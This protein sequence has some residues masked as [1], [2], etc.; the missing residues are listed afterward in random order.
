MLAALLAI[1][2][3]YSLA[4]L[5]VPRQGLA[6][7]LTVIPD[8]YQTPVKTFS[9]PK[10]PYR[11]G[12]LL[13]HGYGSS[14]E[15]MQ[16]LA[17]ELAHDGFYTFC[18]D[19]PGCGDSRQSF[20]RDKNLPAL[21]SAYVDLLG[22]G[23]L[24]PDKVAI[25][26][27]SMGGA[28]ALQF[29]HDHQE[30][31]AAVAISATQSKVSPESPRNLLLLTAHND[32]PGR[33]MDASRMLQDAAPDHSTQMG[34]TAGD[35]ANG[36]ARRAAVIPNGNHLTILFSEAASKEIRD[37]LRSSFQ[38]DSPAA[39]V[40]PR[41][42]W[43]VLAHLLALLLF[44]PLAALAASVSAPEQES[45]A[46]SETS[47]SRF[48][49]GWTSACLLGSFGAAVLPDRPWISIHVADYVAWA[50]FLSA[51]LLLASSVAVGTRLRTERLPVLRPLVL[52]AGAFLFLYASFGLVANDEWIHLGLSGG[53]WPV[54]A[55]VSLLLAPLIFML[56]LALRTYQ[57]RRGLWRALPAS[58]VAYGILLAGLMLPVL[59]GV[60][61]VDTFLMQMSLPFLAA[62][63][64]I[65]SVLSAFLY[66]ATRSILCCAAWNTLIYGWIFSASFFWK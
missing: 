31:R 39:F 49:M 23:L 25:L 50:Y 34:S 29:A 35:F 26:G 28:L 56:E 55:R 48:L 40:P 17:I 44:V 5:E 45:L 4:Q 47:P 7:D 63:F 3:L 15:M 2:F 66:Q 8:A 32:L 22:R 57:R 14:K 12:V 52:A 16:G 42:R 10:P 33:Q 24:M 59:V 21:E 62:F 36:T 1:A 13:L 51:V 18:L 60:G 37:W 43:I 6:E 20:S 53:R 65:F 11:G 30:V 54:M 46:V 27:H 38:I 58:S 64:I 41:I 9:P 61:R 19:L